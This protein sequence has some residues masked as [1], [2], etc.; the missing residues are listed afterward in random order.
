MC[1]C[2]FIKRCVNTQVYKEKAQVI[3]T[4]IVHAISGL[5]IASDSICSLFICTT[6]ALG[7]TASEEGEIALSEIGLSG[8]GATSGVLK[9]AV[10]STQT[11][12]IVIQHGS[13]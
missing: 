13:P 4:R 11:K 3:L 8:S 2:V 7:I 9:S 1:I 5:T 10:T 12:E 6:T